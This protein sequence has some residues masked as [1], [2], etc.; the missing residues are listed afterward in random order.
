[1]GIL[2]ISILLVLGITGY[3]LMIR[4]IKKPDYKSHELINRP[5]YWCL[6]LF[7]GGLTTASISVL[8]SVFHLNTGANWPILLLG[9]LLMVAYIISFLFVPRKYFMTKYKK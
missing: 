4:D 7:I 8:A 2:F 3:Y 5:Y 6:L 1:M 9:S